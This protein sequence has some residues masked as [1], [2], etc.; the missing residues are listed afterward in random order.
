MVSGSKGKIYLMSNGRYTK[1]S[2]GFR[3][4]CIITL[5]VMAFSCAILGVFWFGSRPQ[6]TTPRDEVS[7]LTPEVNR[8]THVTRQPV[9]EE[10][11][12]NR[13]L[14]PDVARAHTTRSTASMRGM[15][16]LW[17]MGAGLALLLMMVHY[18]FH[19]LIGRRLSMIA[20]HLN[21]TSTQGNKITLE[22]MNRKSNDEISVVISSINAMLDDLSESTVSIENLNREI[23]E[24]KQVER[25]L[26]KHQAQ[27]K[28]LTEAR[29]AE[30]HASEKRLE[31]ALW[32][33]D[34]GTWDWNVL[35]GEVT[36]NA[37]WADIL[38]YEAKDIEP[39]I[40]GWKQLIHPD[41]VERVMNTVQDNLSGK[42]PFFECEH[43]LRSKAG[44]WVW[45]LACGKVVERD[46]NGE[47]LRHAGTH[48]NINDRKMAEEELINYRNNLEDLVEQRT[49]E[50]K[51]SNESLKREID[52]R[53]QSEEALEKSR[54]ELVDSF[55]KLESV[56][57]HLEHQT[58]LAKRMAE[59]AETANTAKSQFLANMSHEIRTPMNTIVGFNEILAEGDLSDEQ[60]ENINV[61]SESSYHLLR[62]IDDILDFSKI[63]AGQLDV[64][65]ID[66]DLG[67]L[68]RSLELT[69]RPQIREKALE[70]SIVTEGDLPAQVRSD[71]YR[72]QQCLINL[73][74]NAIKFTDHGHVHLKV[75]LHEEKTE[76][77][78]RFEVEDTGIG[79][80]KD[81]QE[82]IFESFTQADGS[83]SRKFGGTGL[84]LAITRQLVGLLGGELELTSEVNKGS[85]FTLTVPTGIDTT[86]QVRLKRRETLGQE[87]DNALKTETPT[88]S[89]R[90]LVAEDVEG[91]QK[92]ITVLLSM[93][94]VE[95]VVADDGRQAVDK[96]LSQSFDLVL[97]DMQMPNM[98][99]Y[100]ATLA[101]KQKG[102]KTPIVALT[103]NAMKGDD[104]KCKDA[105]CDGYLT[106]PIDRRELPRLLAKY[107]PTVQAT[108]ETGASVPAQTSEAK[109]M[110]SEQTPDTTPSQAS[111]H[112][113]EVSHT[114]DFDKL[115]DE[116]GDKE[117]VSNILS[118]YFN[119]IVAN[120]D[121][122]CEAVDAGHGDSIASMAHALKGVGR[123]LHVE[124]LFNSAGPLESAGRANDLEACTLHFK[125]VKI[126]TEKV[127][128]ALSQCDWIETPN[129]A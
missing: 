113:L 51:A 94:G 105:G 50:L 103:A 38:G 99:G 86:G 1:Q 46:A 127:L 101:L 76:Q 100:E 7:S 56:N 91:N 115:I 62:L 41:D 92:L 23:S 24:R 129:M 97:M 71:P 65:I 78:L 39:H 34:L 19:H 5:L 117:T 116:W 102:Y 20:S 64:D 4:L 28:D 26:T 122:L 104:Q 32:A 35:T 90:V 118:V 8:S 30:L 79:I 67:T 18:A 93:L 25:K 121:R 21:N 123:N 44:D 47:A 83:T 112:E 45:V 22:P 40:E 75:S 15:K 54:E 43:R 111:N 31:L 114:V 70:F 96:A 12:D 37:H 58:A 48:Q 88:F 98:N 119:D 66:C 69:V 125:N 124:A 109:A 42:L 52:V 10:S 107:L 128:T 17:I 63:E 36:F 108:P 84:G 87:R 85:A 53:S 60:R 9:A 2:I 74:S 95:V 49:R 120:F 110:N 57:A 27:L 89:G 55:K 29:T 11:G 106:K 81:R 14:T 82:T 16:T 73:L 126:Q 3:F 61:V 59:V 6:T 80:P 77:V 72:L 33:A 13:T 68:L